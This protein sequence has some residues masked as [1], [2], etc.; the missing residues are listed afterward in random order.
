MGCSCV[1]SVASG[2]PITCV[3]SVAARRLRRFLALRGCSGALRR[4]CKECDQGRAGGGDNNNDNPNN[5]DNIPAVGDTYHGCYVLAVSD[6]DDYAE[7]TLLSP[8]EFSEIYDENATT[9]LANIDAAL[10]NVNIDGTFRMTAD[11][12]WDSINGYTF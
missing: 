3:P 8:T 2:K 10:G 1:P 5:Q 4:S 9:M 12:E 11:P 7:V 6:A